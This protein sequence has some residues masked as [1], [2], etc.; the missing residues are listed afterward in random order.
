M[1]PESSREGQAA[2]GTQPERGPAAGECLDPDSGQARDL[3]A[4]AH[5][6]A[7]ALAVKVR[8]MHSGPYLVARAASSHSSPL[9]PSC[10][11]RGDGAGLRTEVWQESLLLGI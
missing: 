3:A 8:L 1:Q 10:L 2:A 9:A 6:H 11:L 4:A 5:H 7:D